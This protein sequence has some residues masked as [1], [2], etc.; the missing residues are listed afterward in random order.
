M[1]SF[2]K[3]RMKDRVP[4]GKNMELNR[5]LCTEIIKGIMMVGRSERKYS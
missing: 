4:L 5:E 3:T 1:V 2:G